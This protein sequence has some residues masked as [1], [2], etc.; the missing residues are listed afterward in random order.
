[1][2]DESVWFFGADWFLCAP[3]KLEVAAVSWPKRDT[4][5]LSRARTS[6]DTRHLHKLLLFPIAALD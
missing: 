1:M 4:F 5:D 6:L 3:N 2:F